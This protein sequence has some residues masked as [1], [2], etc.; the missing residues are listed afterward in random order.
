MIGRSADSLRPSLIAACVTLAA[1]IGCSDGDDTAETPTQTA[2]GRNTTATVAPTL[3]SP[4]ADIG[5]SLDAEAV[6][7]ALQ[8][9]GQPVVETQAYT[10]ETDPNEQLGRPHGYTSKANFADSRLERQE[11]DG[12]LSLDS[13]GS[14]EV[15]D[16]EED[17]KDR[18][19]Y[20]DAVARGFLGEYHYLRDVTILRLSKSFTPD[21]AA[22]YE[23]AFRTVG[24]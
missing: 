23:S 3:P 8:S 21:Q 24:Q 11:F 4:S 7:L 15:F 20:L 19:G 17:A 14:V 6:I 16:N 18:F 5:S 9:A 22:E 13:G 12:E 10:A 2:S 1:A